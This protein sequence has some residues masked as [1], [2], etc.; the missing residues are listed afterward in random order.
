M[1]MLASD[2]DTFEYQNRVVAFIDVL[3]SAEFAEQSDGS[4]AARAKIGK[5]ITA[6][7][8]FEQFVRKNL[9]SLGVAFAFFSDSFVLSMHA[10]RVLYLVRETGNFCRYLLLQG[11]LCRG[12]I[13]AGSLYHHERI[14]VGPALVRA[15]RSEQ[16]AAIY[17]RVILDDAAM[18]YWTEEFAPDSAHPSFESLVKLDRDGQHFIDIFNPEWAGVLPW[19]SSV[20]TDPFVFLE[21]AC[22]Q[23]RDGRTEN[24]G[25]PNVLRKYEWLATECEERAITRKVKGR[26]GD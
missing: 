22:K 21:Q 16:C 6:D 12:A 18:E 17:P 5:L 24:T 3:G 20:P 23:V 7:K 4:P 26:P 25:R 11:L 9:G 19:A 13:T 14:V 2:T 8:L 10:D 1:G 15:Y